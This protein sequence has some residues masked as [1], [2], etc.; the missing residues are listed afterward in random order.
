M[1]PQFA[2]DAIKGDDDDDD[3]ITFAIC[4]CHDVDIY[5]EYWLLYCVMA[6]IVLIF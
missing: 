1:F 6:N 5:Y 4:S 2:F 3:L